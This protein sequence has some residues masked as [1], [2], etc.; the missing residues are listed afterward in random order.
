MNKTIL[1]VWSVSQYFNIQAK[2]CKEKEGPSEQALQDQRSQ[3][4]T[5][6]FW[7]DCG[8]WKLLG[9]VGGVHSKEAGWFWAEDPG[10]ASGINSSDLSLRFYWGL[11][12]KKKI[13]S[14]LKMFFCFVFSS[15]VISDNALI[16]RHPDA[17]HQ[18][19]TVKN[20]NTARTLNILFSNLLLV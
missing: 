16:W 6:H 13:G 20:K 17:N 1:Q 19:K 5:E 8:D 7:V 3:E 4:D 12:G 15:W 14:T 2:R 10:S 9:G 11:K 18:S